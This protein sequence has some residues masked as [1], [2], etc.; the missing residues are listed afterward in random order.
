VKTS[1]HPSHPEPSAAYDHSLTQYLER[2]SGNGDV[3]GRSND[4]AVGRDFAR[5]EFQPRLDEAE[6]VEV[7]TSSS[8]A[9]ALVTMIERGPESVTFAST[10]L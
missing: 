2:A 8:L 9:G 7:E 3:V 6:G 4:L 10:M 1:P 5:A